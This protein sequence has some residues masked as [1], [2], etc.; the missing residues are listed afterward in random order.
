M[1]PKI[2]QNTIRIKLKMAEKGCPFSK[3]PTGG[4]KAART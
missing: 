2:R 1:S 4:N 3:R